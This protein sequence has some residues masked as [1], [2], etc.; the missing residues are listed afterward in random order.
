[1]SRQET[2]KKISA[3]LLCLCLL[4][5]QDRYVYE[6]SQ[7]IYSRSGGLL[8]LADAAIY[9]TMYR[10]ADQGYVTDD[11]QLV[12][13]RKAR[14]RVYYHIT[15]SGREYYQKILAAHKRSMDGLKNFFAHSQGKKKG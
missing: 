13:E 10:L 5:E 14:I 3:E 1:M 8:D 6:I 15:D 9:M 2:T 4:N 7:E 12:G 11:R